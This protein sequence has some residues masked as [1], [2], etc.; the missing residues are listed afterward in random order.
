MQQC[1]THQ[2]ER[3]GLEQGKLAGGEGDEGGCV[4]QYLHAEV[5]C[6]DDTP[7]QR[8]LLPDVHLPTPNTDPLSLVRAH[9]PVV[10]TKNEA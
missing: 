6:A 2:D 5:H 9:G 4:L 3:T 8:D 10:R 1:F 7:H